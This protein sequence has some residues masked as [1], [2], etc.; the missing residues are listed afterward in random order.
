MRKK[1]LCLA[2]TGL[3]LA[4]L[5]TSAYAKDYK[6]AEGWQV[7]FTG[8]K[9]ESNFESSDVT[10]QMSEIQPGD[11]IEL[12]VEL[13][14][15]DSGDTDWYMTNEVVQTLEEAQASAEGGAYQYKISYVGSDTTETVIYD[16]QTVGGEGTSESGEGLKQVDSA[17]DQYFYLGRLESGKSGKVHLTVG[18]EGETQGNG[19]QLTLAKLR[20]NFAAEKVKTS[21]TITKNKTVNE[22]RTLELSN[23]AK[24]S[25]PVR[26]GD[27]IR[28]LVLSL[29]AL[30]GGLVLLGYGIFAFKKESK[31]KKQKGE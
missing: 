1:I 24:T 25:S 29:A 31:R 7:N 18:V 2:M 13:K 12:T 6:G 8:S 26:T 17:T 5:H 9:M 20:M 14:N 21:T 27:S 15:S 4:G 23:A 30:L 22:N 11:T 16:S 28:T 3:M 10:D 19:Y